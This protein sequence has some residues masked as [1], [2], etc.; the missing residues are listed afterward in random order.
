MA[1]TGGSGLG[2]ATTTVVTAPGT[3]TPGTTTPGS[4]VTTT[5]PCSGSV[6]DLVDHGRARHHHD[7][8]DD[9][10]RHDGRDHHDRGGTRPPPARSR[11][12]PPVTTTVPTTTTET[13]PG[14]TTVTN[15]PPCATK[16][17]AP[18]TIAV[19][20]TNP[21][22]GRAMW[23]WQLACQRRRQRR[24]D[25]RAGQALRNRTRSTSRAATAPS[26]WSQFSK[27]LVHRSARGGHAR[28][29]PGSTCTAASPVA[30]A[31]LGAQGRQGRR[32]LPG[33]RRRIRSTRAGIQRRRPTSR[34]CAS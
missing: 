25:H 11:P 24:R 18:S 30:E 7:R 29:A 8:S 22:K 9:G 31:N 19:P 4:T 33:D 23:I 28:S 32:R 2:G 1:V 12:P 13:I 15:T 20:K 5:T 21:F 17:P 14:T 6:G 3:T 10:D 16:A 34:G 26:Y 27:A